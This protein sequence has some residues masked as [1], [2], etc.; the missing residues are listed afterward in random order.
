MSLCNNPVAQ[1]SF[2]L[3]VAFNNVTHL[4]WLIAISDFSVS[5]PEKASAR[6]KA[7]KDCLATHVCGSSVQFQLATDYLYSAHRF[8]NGYLDLSRVI[9]PCLSPDSLLDSEYTVNMAQLTADLGTIDL[10]LTP[11]IEKVSLLT[12][13]VLPSMQQSQFD[14]SVQAFLNK[15]FGNHNS[16]INKIYTDPKWTIV[17]D[18]TLWLAQFAYS[19]EEVQQMWKFCSLYY[20]NYVPRFTNKFCGIL[21]NKIHRYGFPLRAGVTYRYV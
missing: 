6:K 13:N 2:C 1:D 12:P 14:E 19:A 10:I 21:W 11:F 9:A 7:L 20:Q 17:L 3:M 5:S 4:S 8:T 16:L 15:S 18:H